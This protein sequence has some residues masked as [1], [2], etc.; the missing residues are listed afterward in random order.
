MKYIIYQQR[1][2]EKV[3]LTYPG[4]KVQAENTF[5]RMSR[6]GIQDIILEKQSKEKTKKQKE[7]E[8]LRKKAK[9][10]FQRYLNEK[11]VNNFDG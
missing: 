11:S 1:G 6:L 9:K 2:E 4:T 5:N 3:A 8:T 7:V 10:D